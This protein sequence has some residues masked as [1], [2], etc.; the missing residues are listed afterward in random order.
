VRRSVIAAAFVL[1]GAVVIGCTSHPSLANV[2]VTLPSHAASVAPSPTPTASPA[3][4]PDTNHF[5][6]GFHDDPGFTIDGGSSLNVAVNNVAFE[7]CLGHDWSSTA[8][9]PQT[10][11]PGEQVQITWLEGARPAAGSAEDA[12]F[13][14]ATMYGHWSTVTDAQNS[15]SSDNQV[16]AAA[17]VRWDTE[18]ASSAT[19]VI[20]IP[21][22]AAAGF[23]ELQFSAAAHEPGGCG[24]DACA[25]GFYDGAIIQVR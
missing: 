16:A 15:Y 3:P 4:S 17:V 25:P 5:P 1:C 22:D 23:Y 24:T 18:S 8:A 2:R 9:D 12:M 20:T 11:S 13:L 21:A 19:S 7:C 6:A 10:W 14:S